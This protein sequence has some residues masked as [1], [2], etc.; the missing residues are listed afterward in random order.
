M[1]S[2]LSLF[3]SRFRRSTHNMQPST[4]Y[5]IAGYFTSWSIYQRQYHVQNI[6]KDKLNH[7]LY[8]FAN[9]LEDGQVVLTDPWADTD[10]HYPDDPWVDGKNL[11][12][13]FK[14]L[15]LLKRKNRYLRVSLSIGGWTYS[16]NFSQVAA[17]PT[18][19][20]TFIS[21]AIRLLNNL[22]LDG[23]DIDWEY[24]ANQ[25]DAKNYVLL[26]QEMRTALTHY[27]QQK[28][29]SNPYLLTCAVPC[30]ED[31]Y[32]LLELSKMSQY[33]DWFYLM[34]YDFAGS[35]SSKTSHQSNLYGSEIS[36]A[37]AVNYYL[38]Q[39]VPPN[40]LV[41][42]CPIYGR[43][44]AN[45]N[46]IGHSFQGVGEGNWEKGVYDY[47]N[48]PLQGSQEYVDEHQVAS[49]CYSSTTRELVSYDNPDVV[50]IKSNWC[51]Q[52]GLRGIMFWE[53]SAD[54]LQPNRSLVQTVY[55]SFGKD[56]LEKTENH[57]WFPTS[58]YENVRCGFQ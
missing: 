44:F 46:G 43:S 41:L 30:G 37:K 12:G 3:T 24:P 52:Y 27:Q 40:K 29:E 16:T 19:R 4:G 50:R 10:Q 21:S 20:A 17:S 6:P 13:N 54:H 38:S 35:W 28:G 42:G 8:A 9:V 11:Y 36:I 53:L 18:K 57:I 56:N 51:C 14:Q 26:L 1:A 33:L 58:E 31:K 7:I 55:E 49:Y 39:N 32:C 48:L 34:A 2:C 23:I 22:G 25:I 5:I 47:K 15:G 45:T